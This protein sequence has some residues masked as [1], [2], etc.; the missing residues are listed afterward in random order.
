MT[1]EPVTSEELKAL[2]S[3]TP[4]GGPL[5]GTVAGNKS[6]DEE[7]LMEDINKE[8]DI[9]KQLKTVQELSSRLRKR[10][11]LQG[12][13]SVDFISKQQRDCQANFEAAE[14]IFHRELTAAQERQT[15][16]REQGAKVETERDTCIQQHD[17]CKE[18]LKRTEDILE[19][20]RVQLNTCQENLKSI[21]EEQEE[22][23][24]V[25]SK[26]T[27]LQAELG[28]KESEVDRIQNE[29]NSLNQ[30]NSRLVTQ[31]TNL[32]N[33]LNELNAEKTQLEKQLRETGVQLQS[34]LSE[35]KEIED[36]ISGD[37]NNLVKLLEDTNNL[38]K[39]IAEGVDIKSIIDDPNRVDQYYTLWLRQLLLQSAAQAVSSMIPLPNLSSETDLK[40]AKEVGLAVME[41][42]SGNQ[43]ESQQKYAVHMTRFIEGLLGDGY[44]EE[45]VQPFRTTLVLT[46]TR[47]GQIEP[48]TTNA[49][50]IWNSMSTNESNFRHLVN[51]LMGENIE[52]SEQRVR[53]SSIPPPLEHSPM[54]F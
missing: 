33:K 10:R 4:S 18:D 35:Q 21:K 19:E 50:Q 13:A 3:V 11:R 41:G 1:S 24:R 20:I 16:L 31:N 54:T 37:F 14:D 28:S 39:Q 2:G 49:K 44:T 42:I 32:T 51:Y 12:R 22:S 38:Q 40:R 43:Q 29:V 17:V 15:F 53:S 27:E 48:I 6:F 23:A 25:A 45:Q 47:I 52:E 7:K 30:E 34:C 46:T 36:E 8:S 26:I 9:Q 5:Q